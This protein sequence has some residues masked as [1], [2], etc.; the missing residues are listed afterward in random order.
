MRVK[1]DKKQKKGLAEEKIVRSQSPQRVKGRT[2]NREQKYR[3]IKNRTKLRVSGR[4]SR[5]KAKSKKKRQKTG[6]A[7]ENRRHPGRLSRSGQGK[8]RHEGHLG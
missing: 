8:E 4:G 2:L 1:L 3:A 6:N 5:R 7:M